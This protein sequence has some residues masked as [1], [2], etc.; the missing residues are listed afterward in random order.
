MALA[1]ARHLMTHHYS[2]PRGNRGVVL[3]CVCIPQVP[4]P[5]QRPKPGL[6]YG[7]PSRRSA[8][9]FPISPGSIGAWKAKSISEVV[10]YSVPS[11]ILHCG[12]HGCR[13]EA[14]GLSRATAHTPTSPSVPASNLSP[15]GLSM[16]GHRALRRKKRHRRCNGA[17]PRCVTATHLLHD[18]LHG[19]DLPR[20]FP[21]T[22]VHL[23]LLA[24]V[25]G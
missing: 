21:P 22:F 23:R 5:S 7:I 24:S 13:G 11:P 12:L 19:C 17:R 20:T 18:K 1:S 6:R 2:L 3:P 4:N 25:K 10:R 9:V 16:H 15:G 14:F 8:G